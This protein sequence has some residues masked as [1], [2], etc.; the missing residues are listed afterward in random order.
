[1]RSARAIR[2]IRGSHASDP[3]NFIA[4]P[5]IG[6]GVG[7]IRVEIHE[8]ANVLSTMLLALG[9]LPKDSKPH[10]LAAA[11]FRHVRPFRDHPS[12]E[13]LREFYRPPDL[14]NLY[15]HAAQLAG[16]VS[17]APRSS[18]VPPPLDAYEPARMKELPAR[19]AAFYEDAKLG[20]FRR[21]HTAPYTLAAADVKDAIKGA[22]IESFL[23]D[24]YGLPRYAL[25]V[26]PVPT[27]PRSGRGT[28]ATTSWEDIAFL[29]P[30]RVAL[31]S[32]SP[33]AWGLDPRAT[34]VLVQHELSHSLAREAI[35]WQDDLLPRVSAVLPTIPPESRL[36]RAHPEPEQQLVELFILGS[37]VS[38]FRR[39]RGDEEAQRWMATEVR[40]QGTPLIRDFFRAI[41]EFL[42]G[43]RWSD[44]H[45]FLGDLP[46]VLGA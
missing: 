45:A 10:P 6:R 41:E 35:R 22:R 31:R 1:M 30:P 7:G 43:R 14:A 46:K 4:G 2:I 16:P 27:H 26:V 28:S 9:G 19:M 25:L 33:V 34:Q 18:A 12:L 44:L 5:L 29:H 40:R 23:V 11:A 13:W 38:Y 3:V 15:G 24:L 8:P 39:T 20:T 21:A 36:A 42:G 37:T 32:A 17:F